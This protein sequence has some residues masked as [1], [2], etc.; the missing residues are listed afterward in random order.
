MDV[1]K[2]KANVMEFN[3]GKQL[4]QLSEFADGTIL[5]EIDRI[6]KMVTEKIRM[7]VDLTTKNVVVGAE[8]SMSLE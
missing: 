8:E 3:M 4:M 6:N 2:G 5:K 1:L 7:Q